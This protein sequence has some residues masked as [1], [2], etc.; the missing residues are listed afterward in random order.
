MN[1]IFPTLTL[2]LILALSAGAASADDTRCHVPANLWQPT[3]AVLALAGTN[4][5]TVH[6]LDI[7][8]GCY[9][10]EGL[11]RDGRL[12]EARLDPATLEIVE[13]EWRRMGVQ[14][15][16]GAASPGGQPV[17]AAPKAP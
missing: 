2:T 4:G 8:D 10:V 9:E 5:W 17:T 12:F 1:T 3:S 11:E 16:A 7:D 14:G 13:M 6:E 15:P